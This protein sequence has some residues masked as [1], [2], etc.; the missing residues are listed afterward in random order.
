LSEVAE[1]SNRENLRSFTEKLF[2]FYS[3]NVSDKDGI[4][5]GIALQTTMLG[6]AFVN[7]VE[8]YCC[9]GELSLPEMFDLL[10]LFKNFTENKFEIYFR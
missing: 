3:Q 6:E 9:G 7:K 10:S 4:F 8:E 5:T 2:R 1:I